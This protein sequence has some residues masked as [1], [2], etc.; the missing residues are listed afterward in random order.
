VQALTEAECICPRC[1]RAM[2]R[3]YIDAGYGPMRW[4]IRSDQNRT[5]LGG[6]RLVS[7]HEP[8]GR[9]L[10]MLAARCPYCRV[11]LFTYDG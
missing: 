7:H 11:G 8:W 2:D 10:L 6:E 4:A 3:G 1:Q 5:I 9:H